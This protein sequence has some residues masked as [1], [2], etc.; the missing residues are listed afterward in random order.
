MHGGTL[1]TVFRLGI[2]YTDSFLRLTN[3]QRYSLLFGRYLNSWYSTLIPCL[4]YVPGFG[5]T[6]Y[7]HTTKN[8]YPNRIK[9]D[10]KKIVQTLD[11]NEPIWHVAVNRKISKRLTAISY[12][13]RPTNKLQLYG[14]NNENIYP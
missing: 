5:N 6:K 13:T 2:L 14:E 12:Q 3:R 11:G 9:S 8:D 4:P 7:C 1:R 10:I